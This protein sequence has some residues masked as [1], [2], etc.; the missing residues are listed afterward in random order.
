VEELLLKVKNL[1]T[2][3]GVY[4]FKDSFGE[5]IYIGKAKNLKNRVRSYFSISIEKDTKTFQLVQNINDLEYIEVFSE[6][7]A[8]ILEA[9][10]IKQFR[11]KYNI[12][13]KDDKSYLYI[14]IKNQ[15]VEINDQKINLP[16]VMLTRERDLDEKDFNFGPYTS[17]EAARTLFKTIRKIIPFRDCTNIKF[18]RYKRIQ[19]PCL[20]G[21]IGLCPAPCANYEVIDAYKKNVAK[22]KKI[23]NGET[24]LVIKDLQKQ[25]LSLSSEENFEE[26]AVIRDI[27]NKFDYARRTFRIPQSYVDNPYLVEDLLYKSLEE[28]KANI[29][30]LKDIPQVIECYDISNISG[31][32]AVGSLVVSVNGRISKSN[33]RKFRIKLKDTPD[34]FGMLREV[35]TRRIKRSLSDKSGKWALPDLFL[36]DGGKGQISGVLDVENLLGINVPVVGIAKKQ[37]TLVYF[38]GTHFVEVVLPRNNEGLKLVQRLRDEAHR[39]AQAYH[40][41][42][43]LKKI[44]E[45]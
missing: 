8:L 31:K 5:I 41:K 26:A 45:S 22:V 16:Q 17:V 11:P 37:E 14:T 6:L 36:I 42:L 25:M 39:F 20:Y 33:Y 29:P 3:P 24:N 15:V 18:E 7:E 2:V 23:L 21:F 43:R 30:I 10:L 1:P 44:D 35:L 27:L 13:L 34:D 28:L 19:R 32:E 9:S 4:K 40:H 38:D 12:L